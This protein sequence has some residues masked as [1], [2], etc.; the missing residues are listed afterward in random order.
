[1]CQVTDSVVWLIMCSLKRVSIPCTLHLRTWTWTRSYGKSTR[2]LINNRTYWSYRPTCDVT[3]KWS[4]S[5]WSWIPSACTSTLMPDW[6]WNQ[7][8]AVNG[9]PIIS[10]ARS[11]KSDSFKIYTQQFQRVFKTGATVI[12][13]FSKALCTLLEIVLSSQTTNWSIAFE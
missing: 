12:S 9:V 5:V 11:S 4:T 8:L 1:M 13:H 10:R 7:P 6:V 3:A 2:F